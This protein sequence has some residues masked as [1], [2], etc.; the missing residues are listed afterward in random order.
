MITKLVADFVRYGWVTRAL[1]YAENTRQAAPRSVRELAPPLVSPPPLVG[2]EFLTANEARGMLTT[3]RCVRQRPARLRAHMARWSIAPA[4]GARRPRARK[5]CTAR[6]QARTVQQLLQR[7]SQPTHALLGRDYTAGARSEAARGRLVI[8]DRGGS[9]AHARW[10]SGIQGPA[11]RPP[12]RAMV[13]SMKPWPHAPT[14]RVRCAGD[15]HTGPCSVKSCF[16]QFFHATIGSRMFIVTMLFCPF[17]TKV[18]VR[19]MWGHCN[20]M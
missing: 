8:I 9:F 1:E 17:D 5:S 6:T 14:A 11:A 16:G 12:A 18:C 3:A 15:S 19:V 10:T 4:S 7:C 20:V 13:K 2:G